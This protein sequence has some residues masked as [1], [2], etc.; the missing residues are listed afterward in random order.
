MPILN[1]TQ[2]VTKIK[3][4]QMKL[5]FLILFSLLFKLSFGQVDKTVSFAGGIAIR[6]FAIRLGDKVSFTS[7]QGYSFNSLEHFRVQTLTIDASRF[8]WNRH[9]VLQLSNYLRY[10]H[11]AIIKNRQNVDIRE[12]KRLK[13]D[14]LLDML[15]KFDANG[16][17]PVLVLGAGLGFMN[18]NTSFNY[19]WNTGEK[20]ISGNWIFRNRTGGFRFLA[21]RVIVG[22]ERRKIND[23]R[24]S[25]NLYLIAHGTPDE[26]YNA[27]PTIWLELKGSYTFPLKKRK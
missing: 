11:V 16:K 9:W 5:P 8:I 4:Y 20:D 23:L 27:I 14:H 1:L 12:I 15:Y 13:R 10:G 2:L 24:R 25:L 7:P 21:P 3:D 26:D 17:K 18:C 22:I 6:N 19:E